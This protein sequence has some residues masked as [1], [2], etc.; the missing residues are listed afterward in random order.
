[1]DIADIAKR[2]REDI[3]A[4][5]RGR[6]LPAIKSTVRVSRYS[7]GQSLTVTICGVPKGLPVENHERLAFMADHPEVP[8][9]NLPYGTREKHSP[10]LL[11]VIEQ[12]RA[13]VAVYNWDNSDTMTDYLDVNFYQHIRVEV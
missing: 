3:K 4:A 7:G 9:W 12:V 10:E 13:I 8:E 5:I 11:A 2:V 1:M 6:S